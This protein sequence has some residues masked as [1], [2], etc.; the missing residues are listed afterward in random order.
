MKEISALFDNCYVRA[1]K[2]IKKIK[3]NNLFEFSVL[4]INPL[5]IATIMVIKDILQP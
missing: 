3:Q 4:I 5:L 2:Q 1:F